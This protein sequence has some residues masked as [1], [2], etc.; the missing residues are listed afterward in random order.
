M[1]IAI[2]LLALGGIYVISNQKTESC[3]KEIKKIGQETFTNM[4]RNPNYLPN[5]DVPPQ[6]YPITNNKQLADTVQ[7]YQNPN[8]TTDKYFNQNYFEK[9]E[10]AGV[11]VGNTPQQIYSMSGN[12]L[13][14]KSFKH[15]N[16]VPFD[17]GKIKG[18]TYHAN[19]A[20]SVLDNMVGTGSQVIKKIEQAPLFKPEDNI[21]WTYGMP[22]QSDFMQSR[23][24]P[25]TRNNNVKPF[26]SE[27]VGPGLNRGYTT[28]GSGGFNSGMEARDQWLPK[29]VDELRVSTNPKLEYN[30]NNLEGPSYAHVQNVGILGRVE[31]QRPDTF[32]INTQDRWLTTTGAEKGEALRPIQEMGILRRNSSEINYPGPA[33]PAEKVAGRVPS[34]FEESRR[35]LTATKDV[36]HASAQGHGPGMD[37]RVLMRSYTNYNNNRSTVKPVDTMRSG[38]SGAIGAAIAPL[39]DVFRPSRKQ[40]M[41]HSVRI[42]GD[43]GSS[44]PSNY[45]NNPRD[46]TTTTIKETTMY[47]PNFYIN[48]QKEGH[49]VDT[50]TPLETTQRESTN[51]ETYGNVGNNH[52]GAMEYG[53]VYRQ[54]NNDIKMQTIYN[55]ANMGGTQIFNQNMNVSID[56]SDTNCMDNRPFGPSSVI[57][58]PPAKE[59]YGHMGPPQQLDMGIEIQ[60]NTPD[61]LNAFRA[62]PFTHSLNTSV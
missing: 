14:T 5:A 1:E 55:R 47:S 7:E 41:V 10:N 56:K 42:Y 26:E 32:F 25:G 11:S 35:Q 54:Q 50:H 29:T 28:E 2:P 58:L 44:V 13:D 38:F 22:N 24:N 46:I 53:S 48:N 16:M 19:I 51:Y 6:N 27:I 43:A 15:N 12:Y 34:N 62:N 31:K 40:E 37:G 18:Y 33:G 59:N 36:P 9:Q 21:N 23:V 30:L 60:R 61:I 17:G 49:Y 39:M 3:K 57:S 8:S 45:V 52:E 20:E 4:G